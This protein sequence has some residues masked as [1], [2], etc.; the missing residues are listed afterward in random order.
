M[1]AP[2]DQWQDKQDLEIA[3]KA[4]AMHLVTASEVKECLELQQQCFELQQQLAGTGNKKP[5]AD[6]LLEKNYIT[7][8]QWQ[9]LTQTKAMTGDDAESSVVVLDL[10]QEETSIVKEKKKAVESTRS[11]FMIME[12]P[13]YREDA[14]CPEIA[15]YQV[16]G[17]LGS[18]AMGTVYKGIQL[19]MERPVAIKVLDRSLSNDELF[20][21]RFLYEAK[22]VAKLNHENIV[23]GIDAG[24]TEDNVYYFIMEFVDGKPVAKIMEQEKKLSLKQALE[25]IFQIARALEHAQKSGIVHRDIKP[26]N[27]MLTNNNVAKLCDLGL[28]R[29]TGEDSTLTV[30][31]TVLGTPQYISPEQARGEKDIDHRSDIYS[32]GASFYHMLTG[33]FPFPDVNP[34]V[35]CAMHLTQPFP[36]PKDVD[37]EIPEEI[38]RIIKKCTEKKREDRY[39]SPIEL[40][41]DLRKAIISLR[42][43]IRATKT[44]AAVAPQERA[45]QS[46]H[47]AVPKQTERPRQEQTGSID[48]SGLELR[49]LAED[50]KKKA[51]PE[52]EKTEEPESPLAFLPLDEEKEKARRKKKKPV[53]TPKQVAAHAARQKKKQQQMLI[54]GVIFLLLIILAIVLLLVVH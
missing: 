5:L 39:Q 38:C 54:V 17:K 36:N 4:V 19:S 52:P 15:G 27:I 25:I 49:P 6:I 28:V 41:A 13:H 23:S 20:V 2:S 29:K 35:V 34:A 44:M 10:S 16:Q 11:S 53:V 3:R 1:A 43:P 24:R 31:G 22:M 51:E 45:K 26:E 7:K 18:G 12:S 40:I 8:L 14:K 48:T 37:A 21:K 42:K 30:S 50:E 33:R 46:E 32:L 47:V 9:N